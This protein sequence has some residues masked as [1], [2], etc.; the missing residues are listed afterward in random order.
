MMRQPGPRPA[1]PK[2]QPL[3]A[4]GLQSAA[5]ALGCPLGATQADALL[6]YLALL[7]RWNRV[8]NLTAIRDEAQM[9]T[10][11]LLDSLAV[12]APLDRHGAGRA[13]QV[14]DV[15]SGGGL[16]GVVIAIAR[17]AWAVHCVDAVA[18]KARF[19]RQAALE[20]QLQNLRATH[21]RVERLP[22]AGADVVISR[23]FASLADFTG[24]TRHHLADG[25]VWLAMK[26]RAPDDEIAALPPDVAV[27]HVEQLHVPG[28]DAQRRAVW[29]RPRD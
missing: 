6:H 22:P 16:P 29:M 24:W 26:G 27:F 2:M 18:K 4:A 7:S 21:A 19:I 3:D 12:L 15:G 1:L 10:L 9:G 20:L 11:H 13:L 23:A 14:L 28:L 8:Y 17:P 25:G 5:L